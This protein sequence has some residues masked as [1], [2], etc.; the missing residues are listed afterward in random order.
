MNAALS[1][2]SLA[3]QLLQGRMPPHSAQK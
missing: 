3:S 1:H 2:P